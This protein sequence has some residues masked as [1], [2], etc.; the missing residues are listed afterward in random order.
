MQKM[1]D[2]VTISRETIERVISKIDSLEKLG[3]CWQGQGVM[4]SQMFVMGTAVAAP[5]RE[6]LSLLNAEGKV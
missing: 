1:T 3:T 5:C 6:L 2:T 4:G